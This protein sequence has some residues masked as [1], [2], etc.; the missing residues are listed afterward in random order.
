MAGWNMPFILT[1][2][3]M[4]SQWT[5]RMVALLPPP[6]SMASKR[7]SSRRLGPFQKSLQT[8]TGEIFNNKH[9]GLVTGRIKHF[10]TSKVFNGETK[11]GTADV[12]R[13]LAAHPTISH[14]KACN[15][16]SLDLCA[17]KVFW[18]TYPFFFMGILQGPNPLTPPQC[19]VSPPKK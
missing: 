9:L 15:P 12:N 2:V 10:T 11:F 7:T 18:G 3:S 5:W 14:M 1:C 13:L 16:I 8:K 17:A 19:H 6:K 4:S